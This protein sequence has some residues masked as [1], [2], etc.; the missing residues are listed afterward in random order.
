MLFP[1]T[2]ETETTAPP[3]RVTDDLDGWIVIADG[4]NYRDVK[5]ATL[6]WLR[7]HGM[8]L[9]EA[10]TRELKLDFLSGVGGSATI[11]TRLPE[12]A[13]AAATFSVGHG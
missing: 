5:I 4:T 12:H 10:E 6:L 3:R 2:D 13:L 1:E 11:R 7:D 9:G 8:G